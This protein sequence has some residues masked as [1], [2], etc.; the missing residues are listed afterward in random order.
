MLAGLR[1]RAVSGVHHQ[2]RAVHLGGTG[3]HVLDVISMTGT[4]HMRIVTRVGLVFHMR[5]RDRDPARFLF[6]GSVDLV[7]RLELAELL[8]DRRRQRRLAVVNVT[9]RADVAMRLAAVKL[10]LAHVFSPYLM[11][12]MSGA[13]Y[14]MRN[15]KSSICSIRTHSGHWT[16]QDGIESIS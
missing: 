14:V 4:V 7:I 3:D 15:G 2:D 8:R 1:H 12:P 10:F 9:N 11:G 6:R 16:G 13:T 5:R